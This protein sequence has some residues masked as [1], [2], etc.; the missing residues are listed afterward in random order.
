MLGFV[1]ETRNIST[2]MIEPFLVMENQD[3]TATAGNDLATDN[4]TAAQDISLWYDNEGAPLVHS[5]PAVVNIQGPT[6]A[7]TRGQLAGIA[8]AGIE[9]SPGE[10]WLSKLLSLVSRCHEWRTERNMLQIKNK[11]ILDVDQHFTT[12]FNNGP[13]LRMTNDICRH[14]GITPPD[15][16]HWADQVKMYKLFGKILEK[17]KTTP[18]EDDHITALLEGTDKD[19]EE[20]RKRYHAIVEIMVSASYLNKDILEPTKNEYV[21]VMKQFWVLCM[22]M[23]L[24][25]FSNKKYKVV[26]RK[27]LV[28]MG[29]FKESLEQ[30]YPEWQPDKMLPDTIE[31]EYNILKRRGLSFQQGMKEAVD[32][33][34]FGWAPNFRTDGAAD[35]NKLLV[36][37]DYGL[38]TLVYPATEDDVW[39]PL[40]HD[41][42]VNVVEDNSHV[43]EMV[44]K[45]MDAINNWIKKI[46]ERKEEIIKT[47]TLSAP[48]SPK[49]PESPASDDHSNTRRHTARLS[50]SVLNGLANTASRPTR[51]VATG[52]SAPSAPPRPPSPANSTTSDIS[53]N[54]QNNMTFNVRTGPPA[55]TFTNDHLGNNFSRD[56]ELINMA[57][58]RFQTCHVTGRES[59]SPGGHEEEQ[60]N[61]LRPELRGNDWRFGASFPSSQLQTKI[62]ESVMK[63]RISEANTL[64]ERL[65]QFSEITERLSI[66]DLT[67]LDADISA[68]T[69]SAK[70]IGILQREAD[71]QGVAPPMVS[72]PTHGGVSRNISSADWVYQVT[73]EL[74][75]LAS[76]VKNLLR[77]KSDGETEAQK[78]LLK[79]ALDFKIQ[80]LERGSE[81]LRWATTVKEFFSSNPAILEAA[82]ANPGFLLS[83]KEKLKCKADIQ[84]TSSASSAKDLFA[85]L[86]N[87]YLS[88]GLAVHLAFRHTLGTMTRVIDVPWSRQTAQM[89][90][91][92]STFLETMSYIVKL[93]Q[94]EHVRDEHTV[95][96]E[97]RLF[98]QKYFDI[99]INITNR[100]ATA[101]DEQKRE[102]LQK[103]VFGSADLSILDETGVG[104]SASTSILDETPIHLKGLQSKDLI[105]LTPPTSRKLS[106]E[107]YCKI[108]VILG[109]TVK[110]MTSHSRIR[111]AMRPQAPSN[112]QGNNPNRF[113]NTKIKDSSSGSNTVAI[114]NTEVEEVDD[115]NI[116]EGVEVFNTE[117][118]EKKTAAPRAPCPLGCGHKGGIP[119]GSVRWCKKFRSMN[120]QQRKLA[121]R[122]T[123]L[124]PRCLAK[125]H[126]AGKQCQAKI[127]CFH[128][129]S[130]DHNSFIHE[131]EGIDMNYAEMED[132]QEDLSVYMTE[133]MV[134]EIEEID[135]NLTHL[136]PIDP[137][138]T[139]LINAINYD[140]ESVRKLKALIEKARPKVVSID[141]DDWDD[142][143]R[144]QM[145]DLFSKL[146]SS[147]VEAKSQHLA[148]LENTAVDEEDV[149]LTEL[150]KTFLAASKV[151]SV[152]YQPRTQQPNMITFH[153]H[154]GSKQ[155]WRPRN[156]ELL[157]P[158]LLHEVMMANTRYLT[159]CQNIEINEDYTQVSTKSFR[160]IAKVQAC[161]SEI[162]PTKQ[163]T[164][165][166]IDVVIDLMTED[167]VERLSRLQDTL[168]RY[169]NGV[170]VCTVSALLDE[171][172][173]SNLALSSLME[174]LCP[175]KL[176]RI[177]ANITTVNGSSTISDYMYRVCISTQLRQNIHSLP[178]IK[179]DQISNYK[180]YSH[181]ELAT[182]EHILGIDETNVDCFNLSNRARKTYLL[183]GCNE[184]LNKIRVLDSESIGLR[185]NIFSQRLKIFYV[186]FASGPKFTLSGRFGCPPKLICPKD[187]TPHIFLPKRLNDEKAIS[188]KVNTFIRLLQSP[189]HLTSPSMLCRML[190]PFLSSC[191]RYD[192]DDSEGDILCDPESELY[193]EVANINFTMAD[194]KALSNYIES[195]KALITPYLP[196]P[197]HEK[198]RHNELSTCMECAVRNQSNSQEKEMSRFQYLWERVY[199]IEWNGKHRVMLDLP[200]DRPPDQLGQ[201]FHSNIVPALKASVAL[202]KK[203][204]KEGSLKLIDS[205]FRTR[206]SN[207][208]LTPLVPKE[209]QGIMDGTIL[210]QFIL[211]NKVESLYIYTVFHVISLKVN[212][213]RSETSPSRLV[214]NTSHKIDFS[215]STLVSC[216]PCAKHDLVDLLGLSLQAFTSPHTV[217]ADL[218]G[219]IVIEKTFSSITWFHISFPGAYL[220]VGLSE[221]TKY[222]FINIWFLDPMKFG[223]KYPICLKSD[224]LDFGFGSASICLRIAILKFGVPLCKLEESKASI[225]RTTYIDNI[226]IVT[227][228][229][230]ARLAESL[231]D[232]KTALDSLN[233]VVDKFYIPEFI[234]NDPAMNDLKD[235]YSLTFKE[236]TTTL[237]YEW[238][239]GSDSI[240]PATNLTIHPTHRGLPTGE[241]LKF[242]D[243]TTTP[244]TRRTVSRTVAQLWD[245][246]GR[247]YGGAQASAKWLLTRI[248]KL[249]PLSEIDTPVIS[250]DRD[251]GLAC[252]TFWTNISRES[253]NPF[254]RCTL[255][256][257]W[258]I[259]AV[260]QDHDASI[261]L[262]GTALY[263]VSEN[264]KGERECH[265]LSSK[266]LL[267]WSTVVG[268]E[269]RGHALASHLLLTV[270]TY[271]AP[272]IEAYGFKPAI[273]VITDNLPSTYLYREDSK[274]TLPRNVR[275]T[276]LANLVSLHTIMPELSI[277]HCWLPSRFI[278]SDYLTKFFPNPVEVINSDKWRF[279]D[280]VF[281][282]YLTIPHF[283]YLKSNKNETVYRELPTTL[284][285]KDDKLDLRQLINNNPLDDNNMYRV[286]FD[287]NNHVLK[288]KIPMKKDDKVTDDLLINMVA[289]DSDSFN[290]NIDVFEASVEIEEN[291]NFLNDEYNDYMVSQHVAAMNIHTP[292]QIFHVLTRSQAKKSRLGPVPRC[293]PDMFI[294]GAHSVNNTNVVKIALSNSLA[295]PNIIH[296]DL[297]D[298]LLTRTFSV[299]KLINIL[300]LLLSWKERRN[301][302]TPDKSDNVIMRSWLTLLVT[303]QKHYSPDT[304]QVASSVVTEKNVK[305]IA[306][307]CHEMMLPILDQNSP[308]LS[309]IIFSIHHHPTNVDSF[310]DTHTP[311][312]VMRNIVM[313]SNYGVYTTSIDSVLRKVVSRCPGCLR[314]I[315]KKFK[316]PQGERFTLADPEKDL[317]HDSAVDPIGP[318]V[319]RNHQKSRRAG[320]QCFILVVTCHNTGCLVLQVISDLTHQAVILGLKT[321]EQRY[322]VSLCNI[323]VDSGT[324]LSAALLE[325]DNRNWTV[326]QHPPMAHS[327]VYSEAKMATLKPLW[328]KLFGK[329]SK[330]NKVTCPI[331]IY[332]LLYIIAHLQLLVNGIP[333]SKYSAFCP[334]TL[335]HCKGLEHGQMITDLDEAEKG[336]QPLDR[337]A[338]WLQSMR[339]MRNQ[340]LGNV[341]AQRSSLKDVNNDVFEPLEGDVCI[342]LVGNESKCDLVTV[343]KDAMDEDPKH[344]NNHAKERKDQKDEWS[345]RTVLVRA[346]KRQPKPY[347]V[348]SLRLLVEGKKRK[349]KR[350]ASNKE[351]ESPF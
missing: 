242:T 292:E 259:T 22:N 96:V 106:P 20:L 252:A 174:I 235:K 64:Y 336:I 324:S 74:T 224:N 236:N 337:L 8:L 81:Y 303:D 131:D 313:R 33:L 27:K 316:V 331:S 225:S 127:V 42:C 335:L 345:E 155:L 343:C 115:C 54:L 226:G 71:K 163:L 137:G 202:Y 14:L 283:W 239:L 348:G 55:P 11:I 234:F 301:G 201:K 278:S 139:E 56:F 47:W 270:I 240:I 294:K 146:K 170:W 100:V 28:D 43:D 84:D 333:Y 264:D 215:G 157:E 179:M 2:R 351:I 34:V 50:T 49:S 30:E 167:K 153:R 189:S 312:S 166:W 346:G 16:D 124:C 103:S 29:K 104:L 262:A 171:G 187:E 199:K 340:V 38:V 119:L 162:C 76:R 211:R 197:G 281:K 4:V 46:E 165:V 169:H 37:A 188:E 148:D 82:S 307:R 325:N 288:E 228:P 291:M 99:Y 154:G 216:D 140:P 65:P 75:V 339:E 57:L 85:A 95:L 309:R 178:A 191:A 334:A 274:Q 190:D 63:K 232:I 298:Y 36:V 222:F 101:S 326:Y 1:T 109:T 10:T 39:S 245:N 121:V 61:P 158:E 330:E 300:S 250:K 147:L 150:T 66:V 145:L 105:D 91:N 5:T 251:L 279:G 200:F 77:V 241:S 149:N 311:V 142:E 132:E 126:P 203:C 193:E 180:P 323:Y 134:N 347:P 243:L 144:G 90:N 267:S 164:Y 31:S 195:E 52:P 248:C 88:S 122:D 44:K 9:E 181:Y 210:S 173:S 272:V 53:T 263:I 3:E 341:A 97:D 7:I 102:I 192:Y 317:F 212:N 67:F 62:S 45:E 19:S 183:I 275:H 73:R 286:V 123:P 40:N 344:E 318:V 13:F 92:I 194:A 223:T 220:S 24:T 268:N 315:L 328:N 186:P 68:L 230:I 254:P 89:L 295:A 86:D 284:D 285:A 12:T 299:T 111:E 321:V 290:I 280:P 107:E 258:R 120:L 17:Y 231:D 218:K 136:G 58:S 48:E 269:I 182:I 229:D 221:K 314:T 185:F 266:S 15:P 244:M 227:V 152:P 329:F 271:I 319:V 261:S 110:G 327:R 257:G 296:K 160:E 184:D 118:E 204:V 205:Q 70:S 350:L 265:I 98:S 156:G 114:N 273:I 26:L 208:Q 338:T 59:I 207:R 219:V 198:L 342:A 138:N 302:G 69:E 282:D 253:I 238:C 289:E 128:C 94:W 60:F 332:E 233:L 93:A 108:M 304:K 18:E 143:K 249:L 217:M 125:K 305:M 349:D 297:Y 141:L 247:V 255:K 310:P 151:Q 72:L 80:P 213:L 23:K 117:T 135:V 172:S 237:G 129:K 130:P 260:V 6:R 256:P 320:L 51:R 83:I 206:I 87:R 133:D 308:L 196:C 112:K 35:F 168:V 32:E 25:L 322:S 79:G 293:T 276:V 246:T 177:K 161:L 306:L 21:E 214:A 159:A 113:N 277:T 209:I 175:L 176:Y 116:D 78:A 41:A 287:A